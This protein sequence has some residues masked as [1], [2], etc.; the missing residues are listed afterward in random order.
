MKPQSFSKKASREHTSPAWEV[1]LLKLD[2]YVCGAPCCHCWAAECFHNTL[3]QTGG[4]HCTWK[5]RESKWLLDWNGD[6]LPGSLL[7]THTHS[8]KKPSNLASVV[9]LILLINTDG[10]NT[11]CQQERKESIKT[12]RKEACRGWLLARPDGFCPSPQ[13]SYTCVSRET[14]Q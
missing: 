6:A 13:C 7:H 5:S 9:F 12:Q 1:E 11:V 2:F 14:A 8:P 4:H 3:H 10:L